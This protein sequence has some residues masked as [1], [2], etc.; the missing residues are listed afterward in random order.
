VSRVALLVLA[1]LAT[2]AMAADGPTPPLPVYATG[3]DGHAGA[4]MTG[5]ASINLV[6]GRGNAQANLAA[7]TLTPHDMAT[8]SGLQTT[9]VAPGDVARGAIAHIGE[10]ALSSGS[11]VLAVNQASGAANAQLNLL[12]LGG[13]DVA[14]HMFQNVDV[15][16]LAAVASGVPLEPDAALVLPPA[17]DA[18]I[19]G[20]AF[21]NPQG[22]LQLNQTAGVGN[23]S[24]NAIVLQI[25]G[26]TP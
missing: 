3:I 12:V 13:D 10:N 9:A 17:R 8:A 11:G 25:P 23:A 26:G 7:I 6:A 22:V 4:G 2:P 20:A 16:A 15:T 24:A 18:R 5:L 21:A 1:M 14:A 19:D